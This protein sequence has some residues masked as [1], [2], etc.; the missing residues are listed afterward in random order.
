V[1][2]YPTEEIGLDTTPETGVEAALADADL[3]I[4]LTVDEIGLEMLQ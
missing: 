1:I 3:G 2:Q 4:V